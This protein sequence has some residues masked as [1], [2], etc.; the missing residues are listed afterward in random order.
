MEARVAMVDVLGGIEKIRR[1]VVGP[2]ALLLTHSLTHSVGSF[3]IDLPVSQVT[4]LLG[5]GLGTVFREMFEKEAVSFFFLLF[6]P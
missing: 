1:T 6:L 4:S 5:S 3:L 2:E